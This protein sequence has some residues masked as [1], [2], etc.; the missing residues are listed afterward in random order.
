MEISVPERRLT[1]KTAFR[2]ILPAMY[3]S[4]VFDLLAGFFL[5]VNF[6]KLML[7]YPA[8]LIIL[9]GLMGLR[10][11]VFGA[12]GSRISTSLYLGS[13]QPVLKDEFIAKNVFFSIWAATI[14][15]MILM[16]IAFLKFFDFSQLAS[17][18]QIVL[19]SSVLIALLLSVVTA[20]IVIV[21]F[22]KNI[23]PDSIVG[24]SI[25]TFADL[26]SIPSLVLFIFILEKMAGFSTLLVTFSLI[27]L[28]FSIFFSLKN[29]TTGDRRI[30]REVLTIITVLAVIQAITGNILQEFSHLVH[31]VVFLA[32]AYPAVLGSTGN[33]GSVIVART[34][35]KL[36]LGEI[37]RVSYEI[38]H[39]VGRVFLTSLAVSPLILLVSTAF[40]SMY[41]FTYSFT[42]FTIAVFFAVYLFLV[43]FILVFSSLLSIFLYNV[44]VDPDN[45]GIPLVTT[46][47]DVIATAAVVG[48]AGIMTAV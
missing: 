1:V 22:R 40:S 10:G 18:F 27:L 28:T 36:H 17:V 3:L 30:Y 39:D 4:L 21:S 7:H 8:L 15:A 19:N 37:E 24:P 9:P 35:T 6:E 14:P 13:A 12:M 34:S 44:G 25:T 45:G 31:S 47:S 5:G 32:F 46:L 26:I 11:N 16:F 33:Y 29:A 2:L 20:L 43:F 23:D 41:G 42:A 48:M 38:L